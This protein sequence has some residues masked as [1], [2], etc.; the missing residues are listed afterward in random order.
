[1][2]SEKMMDKNGGVIISNE[3]ISIISAIA[4]KSVEGVSGMQNS[5]AGGIVEFLGKKNPSKGVKVNFT[6]DEDVEIDISVSISYGCR[7]QQVA[8]EIQ[9]KVKAEVEA[10]TGYNVKA[11]NILVEDVAIPKDD[12]ESD[13]TK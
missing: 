2:S 7:I 12:K 10:M 11:V 3:V 5:V 13:K 9:E 1:M 8:V 6:E 4:A